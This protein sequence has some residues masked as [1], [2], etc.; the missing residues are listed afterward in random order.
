VTIAHVVLDRDG[1]LNLEDEAGGW[2]LTPEAFVWMPGALAAVR[3]LVAA[4]VHV[5]VATN[6]RC[7]AEGLLSESG[8]AAI[9][10][11]LR[12]DSGVRAIYHCPH[13][14]DAGCR[15]RKPGPQLLERAI[16][17]S[18]VPLAAT[19]FI[20][21]AATDMAAAAAA[22]IAGWLVRTGKGRLTEASMATPIPVFADLPAA[23]DAVLGPT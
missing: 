20:G 10:H 5:S 3:R 2:V 18:G 7:V 23:V 9:H 17:D 6:Q 22:G 1:V 4:G 8:L 19:V 15:C 12:A 13:G 16:R 21:D 11:K 14:A